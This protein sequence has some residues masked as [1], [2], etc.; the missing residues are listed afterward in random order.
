MKN[1]MAWHVAGVM[2]VYYRF[3]DK[4]MLGDQFKCRILYYPLLHKYNMYN[5]L[6]VKQYS[7][8]FVSIL[9]LGQEHHWLW[10]SLVIY[11]LHHNRAWSCCF[12][13]LLVKYLTA[14]GSLVIDKY[15][16]PCLFYQ[17]PKTIISLEMNE[18]LWRKSL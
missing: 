7:Y 15:N 12:F 11:F 1:T 16:V 3:Y 13:T 14:V 10:H 8:Y 4:I 2:V 18:S 5:I 6:Y 17:F 9:W